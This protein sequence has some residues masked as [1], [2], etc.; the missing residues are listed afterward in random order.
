MYINLTLH[1]LIMLAIMANK[2][3]KTQYNYVSNE[4]CIP[5]IYSVYT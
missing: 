3:P 5:F 1:H 4:F 2:S